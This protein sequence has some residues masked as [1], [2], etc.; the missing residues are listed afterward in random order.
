MTNDT[1]L[2]ARIAAALERMS[3]PPPGK[4]TFEAAEAFVW[5]ADPKA[6]NPSLTSTAYRCRC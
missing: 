1:D 4:L 6:S 3:P 5:H 2:L